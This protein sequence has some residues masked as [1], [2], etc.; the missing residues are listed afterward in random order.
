MKEIAQRCK[1]NDEYLAIIIIMER[2]DSNKSQDFKV[3][4]GKANGFIAMK[5]DTSTSKIAY[6]TN[7]EAYVLNRLWSLALG[8]VPPWEKLYEKGSQ[9]R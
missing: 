7:Y 1:V 2:N 6:K 3:K 9:L 5:K 8:W 4:N